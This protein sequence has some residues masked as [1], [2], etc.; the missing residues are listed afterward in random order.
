MSNRTLVF[1][2]TLVILGMLV[3]LSLNLTNILVDQAPN[4]TYLKY[5]NVRGMEV[6]HNQMPYT[7]N[8]KQQNSI[9]DILNLA[10]PINEIPQ[11]KRQIPNFGKLVIYQFQEGPEIVLTPITY[12]AN[13]N[14][15]FSAPTWVSDG[16]LKEIS[17]GEF[18]KLLSQTYD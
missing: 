7:L 6:F 15:I 14:L 5:N 8:F 16:Y 1:L 10:V 13:K 9:I 17:E 4:Q 2:T 11:G 3:L 18:Q 12:D